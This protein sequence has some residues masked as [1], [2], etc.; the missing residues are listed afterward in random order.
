MRT[1]VS[2]GTSVEPFSARR[3]CTVLAMSKSA[4]SVVTP[5]TS[6]SVANPDDIARQRTRGQALAPR[7]RSS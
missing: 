7:D 4:Q 6:Y 5:E 3:C 1:S 2:A